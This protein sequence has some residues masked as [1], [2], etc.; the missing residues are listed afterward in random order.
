MCAD[1]NYDAYSLFT[2]YNSSPQ[3]AFRKSRH[4]SP[5]IKCAETLIHILM[6]QIDGVNWTLMSRE[7]NMIHPVENEL[8]F[9]NDVL[10]SEHL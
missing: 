10:P 3:K 5:L 9:E 6:L 1:I 4:I 7:W 8:G 2:K